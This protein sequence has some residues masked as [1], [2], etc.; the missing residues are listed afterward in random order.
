MVL[1]GGWMG[2]Q[3]CIVVQLGAKRVAGV[4]IL[5]QGQR[6]VRRRPTAT[7]SQKG[8]SFSGRGLS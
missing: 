1:W 5:R 2:P 4:V 6:E 7:V 3:A 8:K